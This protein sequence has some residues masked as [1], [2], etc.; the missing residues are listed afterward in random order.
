MR[1]TVHVQ[2]Y[3][4]T[5]GLAEPEELEA[6]C[7]V[8]LRYPKLRGTLRLRLPLD[9]PLRSA[10]RGDD[11]QRRIEIVL[12]FSGKGELGIGSPPTPYPASHV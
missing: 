9:R 7:T 2:V 8:A 10:L 1:G 5:F 6:Q 3:A 12:A 11:L 4:R